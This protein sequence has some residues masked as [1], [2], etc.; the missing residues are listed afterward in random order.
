MKT[1][2]YTIQDKLGIHARPAGLIVKEAQK[3]DVTI[4]I[5][6]NGKSADASK[7]IA[8][9]ALGAKQGTAVTVKVEGADEAVAMEEIK[10]IFEANL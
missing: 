8:V 6:A 2:N 9:M 7:I 1:F 3:Y 5:E 4:T 10:K